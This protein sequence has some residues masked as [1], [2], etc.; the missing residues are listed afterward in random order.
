MLF[1]SGCLFADVF[2][3]LKSKA[4]DIKITSTFVFQTTKLC[5]GHFCRAQ[6]FQPQLRYT[7]LQSSIL[8]EKRL[9]TSKTKGT[10]PKA[11]I[12]LSNSLQFMPINCLK[13]ASSC[14]SPKFF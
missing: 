10:R 11:R 3:T 6:I 5:P 2:A 1:L 7:E 14:F 12:D 8:N 9:K 13:M 4:K